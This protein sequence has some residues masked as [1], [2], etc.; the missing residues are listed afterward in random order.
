MKAHV[1]LL[2]LFVATT[3][4]ALAQE[5]SSAFNEVMAEVAADQKMLLEQSKHDLERLSKEWAPPEPSS[6][7]VS[8]DA[9]LFILQAR[10]RKSIQKV[11]A[12]YAG[13]FGIEAAYKPNDRAEN[14]AQFPITAYLNSNPHHADGSSAIATLVRQDSSAHSIVVSLVKDGAGTLVSVN[15]TGMGIDKQSVS[16]KPLRGK[17]QFGGVPGGD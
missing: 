9:R 15:L 14:H 4:I 7:S 11:W 16:N 13:K 3:N 1:L 8:G 12:Y 5:K 17:S 2:T 10:S 6:V